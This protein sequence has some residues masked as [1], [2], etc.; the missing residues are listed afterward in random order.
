MTPNGLDDAKQQQLVEVVHPSPLSIAL[1]AALT[2]L[3]VVVGY[4]ALGLLPMVLFALGFVGGFVAWLVVPTAGAYS[5]I[6]DPYFL[7]L[8]LFAVHKLEERYADFFPAL[9]EITGVP[10]PDPRSYAAVALYV[11]AAGWLLIPSLMTRRISFGHFLA[12][13]FFLSMGVI[14][15]AHFLFPLLTDCPYGYFPGMGSVIPLAPAAWWGLVRLVR[16]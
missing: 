11:A 3:T 8:A 12:W 2:L 16:G 6:R 1:A 13:T 5:S 4:W 14:E 10:T 7:T 9:S 15:L